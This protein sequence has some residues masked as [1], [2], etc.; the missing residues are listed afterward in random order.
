MPR[1]HLPFAMWA[2]DAPAWEEAPVLYASVGSSPSLLQPLGVCLSPGKD[3]AAHALFQLC[4][5][6]RILCYNWVNTQAACLRAQTPVT[7][8]ARCSYLQLT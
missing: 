6:K 2:A 4:R 1:E 7:E 8:V 3:F 5:Q